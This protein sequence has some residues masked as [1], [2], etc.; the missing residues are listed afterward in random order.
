[1]T[2]GVQLPYKRIFM[3]DNYYQR[4]N[5]TCSPNHENIWGLTLNFFF[6]NTR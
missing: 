2:F 3:L 1:M 4:L 6:R 5:C